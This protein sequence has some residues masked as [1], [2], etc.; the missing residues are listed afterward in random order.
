MV[1]K[2]NRPLKDLRISVIDQ[3]N[4]RCSYCMPKELFGADHVFLPESELLSFDEITRV[5]RSFAS[6]GV[7]KIRITGGEPLLR[8]NLPELI[9]RL[10]Y[11]EGIRDIALTTN[12]IFLPKQAE[13]LK[14]AGLNR[15]NLSLDA[16]EDRV[17]R[18]VNGRGVKISPVLKG[19]EAARNSGLT[20]KVNM[21]VKKGMNEDQLLPM[22][23]YF[24]GGGVVL[25][26]IEFMDVGNSNGWD[27]DHV[28]TKKQILNSIHNEMPLVP[29]EPNYYGEVADR[30]YYEDG[31]GEIGII[32]SVTDSF[33]ST[34]TRAR[35]SADGMLYHCLFASDGYSIKNLLRKD[36]LSDEALTGVI[37]KK[38]SHRN[39]R[40]SDERKDGVPAKKKIEMSYIGG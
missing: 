18:E 31:E 8:K 36:A 21:V 6:L 22:A 39:D 3:C 5:A 17:F 27:L 14:E 11:I 20:V 10:T 15:I 24:K 40:Y 28:L 13:A 33:C 16:I 37:R 7:E 4:F 1:D 23:R 9:Q 12:G 25:R 30:Y 35:I 19:I 2:L 26:F 34:C 29:A 38:W 32:S